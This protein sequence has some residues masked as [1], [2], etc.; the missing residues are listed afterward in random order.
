MTSFQNILVPIDFGDAMQ[1]AIDLAVS[2]ASKLDARLTL[3]NAFDMTPFMIATPYAPPIDMEPTVE[4]MERA[5]RDVAAEVRKAWGKTES[6][7]VRG[8][9]MDV[10]LETAAARGCDLIVIGSHGRH[11]FA[12]VMLGSIAEKVV[13][14]SPLPVLTVHP[15]RRRDTKRS[16]A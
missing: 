15:V 11:G 14:F 7:L 13:R 3:V 9:P 16:A 10:I 6:V 8:T 12:R 4:A 5:L 1:P 2:L